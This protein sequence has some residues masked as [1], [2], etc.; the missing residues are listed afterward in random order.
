MLALSLLG[1]C[2][3][4]FVGAVKLGSYL[5]RPG[6]L[7]IFKVVDSKFVFPDHSATAASAGKFHIHADS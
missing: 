3:A 4:Y 6:F 1:C 5:C 2:H 7:L